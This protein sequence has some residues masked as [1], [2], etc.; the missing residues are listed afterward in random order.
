[1]QSGD[2]YLNYQA[3]PPAYPAY[4]P[5]PVYQPSPVYQPPPPAYNQGYNQPFVDNPPQ[6]YPYYEPNELPEER[7]RKKRLLQLLG[8]VFTVV[9]LA[10]ILFV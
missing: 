9:I 2:P 1:M 10:I 7:R 8:I 3:S 4:Q 6:E 5:P